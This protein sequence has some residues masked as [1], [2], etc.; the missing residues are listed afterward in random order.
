MKNIHKNV[1][2]YRDGSAKN[3]ESRCRDGSVQARQGIQTLHKSLHHFIFDILCS[4]I[5][6]KQCCA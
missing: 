1:K 4:N 2:G 6:G 5:T 3:I